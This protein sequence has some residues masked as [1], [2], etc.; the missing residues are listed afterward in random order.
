MESWKSILSSLKEDPRYLELHQ[1]VEEAYAASVCYPPKEDLFK[2]FS[3][4]SFEDLKVVIVGQD[5][6]HGEN[7]AHGLAFSVPLGQKLPPSLRNIFKELKSDL[8]IER[9]EGDLSSW[10]REGVLLLNSV[11][12]VEKSKPGS[13]GEFGWQWFTDAVLEKISREKTGVVFILWGSYAQKKTELID[14]GKHLILFSTHPSPFSAH[15]GFLGSEPFS[16]TNAYLESVGK[17]PIS[18]R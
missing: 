17:K 2:A 6:Y 10:A 12:S 15:R 1:K 5:P 7:Q 3:L 13:H 14:P 16:K 11:L 8:G 9:K 4:T 18:W